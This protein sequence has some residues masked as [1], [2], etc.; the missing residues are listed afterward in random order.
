MTRIAC[1]LAATDAEPD[2]SVHR[3]L[4]QVALSHSPRVEDGGIGRVYLDASGLHGLFGD[5]PRL[6]ARLRDM[7]AAA[8][9]TARV[10]IAGSRLAALAA[11]RLGPGAAVVDPDGDAAYLAVAPL[12]L[13]EL[14]NELSARLSRWG[15]RTLGELAALPTA[16][17]FE[18]LGGE[19]VRLQRL[20]R[21]DDPRPLVSWKPALLFEESVQCEWGMETLPPAVERLGELA[22]RVC[23]RLGERGLAADGFEWACRL[24]GGHLHEGALAPAV[25]MTDGA[26]VAAL[27]RLAL[28]ARPPRGI[29]RGLTLRARPARITAMQESLTDRSRPSPRLLAATLNRL[30]GLVGADSIGAPALLDS[31]RPDAVG[32]GAYAPPPFSL[33]SLRDAGA[34]SPSPLRAADAP[35][36][37][38]LRDAGAPPP[39]PLRGEGRVRGI[40]ALALRRLRPPAPA[41]VTLTSG[42]PV[43]LRS[44]RLSGRIVAGAGP[45]RSSG[46]WWSKRPW[47][48]DEWDV[49]L[50]DGTLCRLA[51]DGSAWHLA[52]IYD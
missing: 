50:A 35:S 9:V 6:A 19:G 44:S 10:G 42:R 51:N 16:G 43:A 48:Q 25:P 20:V 22:A 4:L 24:D 27:L 3:M 7:T 14:S 47:L 52:G 45:W 39:S 18:R 13:L 21:G 32:L 28:E 46:E 17:L 34:A 37:S 40:G 36:R 26:A 31:H 12:S 11:A 33:S 49:E 15:L 8:G 30:V 41:A 2:G 38:P 23:A 1:L 5:E 29:V